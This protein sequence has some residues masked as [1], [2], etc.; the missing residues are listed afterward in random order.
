MMLILL[1]NKFFEEADD[2]LGYSISNKMCFEGPEDQLRLTANTQ[3][4]I[5]TVSTACLCCFERTWSA[6]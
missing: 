2:A 6:L 1:L 3:P 4:A 5:L